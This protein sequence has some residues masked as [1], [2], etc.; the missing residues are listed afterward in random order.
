M[1]HR[2]D[3]FVIVFAVLGILFALGRRRWVLAFLG[4]GAPI[5][6]AYYVAH[7]SAWLQFKSFTITGVFALTLAFAGVAALH[8]NRRRGIS[9]LGW[10]AAAVIAGGVL[11]G[12]AI[13][14]HDTTLAPAARYHDLAA[15][16]KRYAGQGPALFPGFDEYAEYFLREEQATSTVEPAH[17]EL[18]LA[19]GVTEPG[20]SASLSASTSSVCPICRGSSSSSRRAARWLFGRRQLGSRR[21]DELL[22]RVAARPSRRGRLR[23]LSP[24]GVC[25]TSARRRSA[26]ACEVVARCRPRRNGRLRDR[27]RAQP[28]SCRP[29]GN[30]LTTGNPRAMSS[31]PTARAPTG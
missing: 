15:I 4:I 20:A 12:N 24:V 10:L 16:G 25:P 11:Y 29:P 3:V 19:P 22:R 28:S 26:A 13:V 17:G 23:A 1:T 31:S 2:L 21:A 7:S 30:T 18:G 6:L 14:Y 5:A 27:S 8:E 9:L